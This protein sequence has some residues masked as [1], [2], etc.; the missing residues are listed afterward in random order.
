MKI[1]EKL[2]CVLLGLAL[3][4]A[5]VLDAQGK[6][7]TR[8]GYWIGFGL[9]GG[10]LGNSCDVV[11]GG[12]CS[13]GLESSSMG[14]SG[15]LR[16]GGTVSPKLL[17]AGETTG[18]LGTIKASSSGGGGDAVTSAKSGYLGAAVYYYPS[19]TGGLWLRGGL[20]YVFSSGHNEFD[21][22]DLSASAAGLALGLGYDFRVGR[23][24]SI[25]PG[26]G[27]IVS[28]GGDLKESGST[29]ATSFKTTL[30]A[31]QVGVTFH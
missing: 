28:T 6:P 30:V 3:V 31:L 23:M 21:G 14:G 11:G 4:G 19:V 12:S 27:V 5:G 25:V 29:V 26:F 7:Q 18:W 8:Q 10:S 22:E 17:I 2:P 15:Y 20:G 1:L 13:D 24:V 16:I 9:G